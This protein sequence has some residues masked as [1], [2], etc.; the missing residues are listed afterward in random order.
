MQWIRHFDNHSV[1]KRQVR[2]YR[3]PVIQEPGVLQ[4]TLFVIQ[5]LFIER[6]TNALH[7]TALHLPFHIVRV[8]RL[9]C[10][11]NRGIARDGG[12]AGF[13]V[14]LGIANVHAET[15]RSTGRRQRA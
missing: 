1:D 8:N 5:I 14:D 12:T 11:L 4:D 9:A 3:N 6:P 2:S 10:V 13:F 7:C 15:R